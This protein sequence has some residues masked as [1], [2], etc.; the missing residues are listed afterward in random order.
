MAA[1]PGFQPRQITPY[2]SDDGQELTQLAFSHDGKTLVYVRGGD[3][4]SSRGDAPNPAEST[5]Q[6]KV[7][8]WSILVAG[9][10]PVLVGDGD[11]PVIAPD[12]KRVAF[13]RNQQIWFA[14][15]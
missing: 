15:V 14:S 13:V 1:P 5:V 11:E 10:E 12:G 6:P 8:I 7:Q 3:H 2:E 4:G 9:G